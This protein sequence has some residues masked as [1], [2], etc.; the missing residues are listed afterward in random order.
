MAIQRKTPDW[1]VERLALGELDAVTAADVRQRLADEGRALD[2]ELATIATSNREILDAHPAAKVGAAVRGR[3]GGARVRARRPFW[4]LGGPLAAVGALALV[5]LVARPAGHTGGPTPGAGGSALE[6][7]GIKGSTELHVYRHGSQG[8]ERLSEGARVARGD[9]LQLTYR[10]SAARFGALLSIDGR[11]HVTLHWPE[12]GAEA[13]ARLSAKGE[14]RVP[15]AYEL[16]DAPA[17]ERFILITADAPFPIASVLDAGRALAA[18]P[19]AARAQALA[20]PTSFQ[21][22]S[23]TLTKTRKETP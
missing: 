11:G 21:Q 2:A 1:L 5:F 8:D 15:A 6:E 23:L 12:P 19:T 14:V 22:T 10:A 16:D 17:F 18:Q 7:T 4:L 9:L 13:A 20:L 3:A